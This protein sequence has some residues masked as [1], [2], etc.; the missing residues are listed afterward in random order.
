MSCRPSA[1]MLFAQTPVYPTMRMP[2]ALTMPERN[3]PG[4][5]PR[6]ERLVREYSTHYGELYVI[7]GSLV[8]QQGAEALAIVLPH[9]LFQPGGPRPTSGSRCSATPAGPWR[10]CWAFARRPSTRRGRGVGKRVGSGS[11]SKPGQP[12]G[13]EARDYL[14]YL[15]D[16]KKIRVDMY[17]T[18]QHQR[19]LGVVWDGPVIVNLLMAAMGYAEVYRG[20]PCQGYCSDLEQAESK[21][22]QHRGGMWAQGP[23]L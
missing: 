20:A 3:M 11:V 12:F 10:W 9:I 19:A 13:Q 6:V 4:V 21:A 16:G 1:S 5:W 23:M 17:G 15:L 8:Q 22:K 7:T 18:D 2:P 14:D